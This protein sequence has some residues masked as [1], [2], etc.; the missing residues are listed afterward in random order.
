MIKHA[1]DQNDLSDLRPGRNGC[2]EA[3]P[4]VTL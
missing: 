1:H 2:Y 4:D 3:E